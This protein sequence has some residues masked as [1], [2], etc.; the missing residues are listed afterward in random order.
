M[1]R[2]TPF[3]WFDG[4]AEQAAE[5]YVRTFNARPSG[6]GLGSRIVQVAR[7]G[8]AGPGTPGSAMT[9]QFELDGQEV[10]A[11]NGGPGHPFTDAFSFVV[12]CVDQDEVDHFWK[13][14]A[15]GGK[16]GPCGWLTDRW[17][18]SWQV[19]PDRL[20]ELLDDPDPG[21]SQRAM[22][23]MLQ[24]GKIEIAELETAADGL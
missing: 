4:Q 20:T 14:L 15:D 5:F 9:V 18:L 1:P 22:R 10:V 17:G 16:E 12:H 2:I 3:L 11:L 7:Y 8:E 21:R 6:E 23:A 13:A 19:V 24:M